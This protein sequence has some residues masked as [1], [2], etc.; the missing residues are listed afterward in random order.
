MLEQSAFIVH[1]LFVYSD[2][3]NAGLSLPVK[4]FIQGS[5]ENQ[6]RKPSIS[7]FQMTFFWDLNDDVFG[8]VYG[9]VL[10]NNHF[11]PGFV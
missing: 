3:L 11:L 10:Q 8:K 2:K 1:I 9:R 4:R 7:R 5:I 6:D